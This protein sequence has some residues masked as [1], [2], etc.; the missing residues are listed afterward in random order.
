[1]ILAFLPGS[2]ISAN[3]CTVNGVAVPGNSHLIEETRNADAIDCRISPTGHHIYSDA[4]ADIV[5]CSKYTDFIE[6]HD[7]NDTEYGMG[8]DDSM[9][10]GAKDDIS[11]G[12]TSDDVLFGGVGCELR[13]TGTF[14]LATLLNVG[15]SGLDFVYGEDGNNTIKG[16][17]TQIT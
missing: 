4:G 17:T 13:T 8:G 11:Y 14:T 3:G 7:G 9:D 16:G 6:V 15:G 2:V 1:L 5:Y 10:G 12:G